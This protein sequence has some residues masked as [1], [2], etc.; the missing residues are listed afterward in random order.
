MAEEAEDG[1]WRGEQERSGVYIRGV[2]DETWAAGEAE[3][4]FLLMAASPSRCCC[5]SGWWCFGGSGDSSSVSSAVY[6]GIAGSCD[7][8]QSWE[9]GGEMED[10]RVGGGLGA[11]WKC[12]LCVVCC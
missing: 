8:G 7:E 12:V 9:D 2:E 4:T 11:K 5:P 1:G 3:C 10:L 6:R